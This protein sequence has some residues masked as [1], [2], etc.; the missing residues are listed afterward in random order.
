MKIDHIRVIKSLACAG[1]ATIANELDRRSKDEQQV[2]D[3]PIDTAQV[4]T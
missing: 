2:S 3:S 1:L 4:L